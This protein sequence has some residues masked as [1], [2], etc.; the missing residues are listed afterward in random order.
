MDHLPA[1]T[2]VRVARPS[3]DLVGAER[4]WMAGIGL[5][6]LWRGDATS[7]GGHRLTM[8]GRSTSCWHLE[9]VD[10]PE[11]ARAHPPGPEDLLVLYLGKPPATAWWTQIEAAGGRRVPS[12][13]PYW[14]RGG[15]TFQD[16]DGYLLV[17]TA[18]TW[19]TDDTH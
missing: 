3:L 16:P 6:V 4:F 8:L 5:E 13:N 18:R 14:D 19:G 17:L 12:R 7:E 2:I 15:V 1:T 11:A 10:D 9:L